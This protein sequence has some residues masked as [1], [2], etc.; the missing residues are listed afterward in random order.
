MP[1]V[2][3]TWGATDSIRIQYYSDEAD[4]E[5]S[6]IYGGVPNSERGQRR[7][8]GKL[9][10]KLYFHL[11]GH[12]EKTMAIINAFYHN[13]ELSDI[14]WLVIADDDTLLRSVSFCVCFILLLVSVYP[15]AEQ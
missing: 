8:L 1:I 14:N 4:P 15:A 7:T 5:Y 9:K 13:D 12:C 6:T 2:Q 3:Q 11:S 10:R